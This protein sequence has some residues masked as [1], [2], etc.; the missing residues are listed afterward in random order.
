MSLREKFFKASH[1]TNALQRYIC[2]RFLFDVF[3][4]VGL[5]VTG[6]HFYEVIPN[7]RLVSE[8]YS[9]GPRTLA[10]IDWRFSDGESRALA[11]ID[12]FG[13]EF[14]ESAGRFGFKEDNYYFRGV[15][16]LM[17]YLVLRDVKP[18]TMV[19]V[20]QGFSTRVALAAL[21]RNVSDTGARVRLISIDPYPRFRPD[22]VPR[23]VSLELIQRRIQDVD[24][25]P[26]L[27]DCRLFF[28]DSSHVF[29]FGSDVSFEL[30]TVYPQLQRDAILH[31]H[32]IFSPF[33]YP[34]DWMVKEK[35]FWN[36]QYF[37]ECFLMFNAAFQVYLPLH[38]L[39]RQSVN[40][41]RAVRGCPLVENFRFIGSSLY[42][43]RL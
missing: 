27:K 17:L 36:E 29:K 20:G 9:D 1:E 39:V 30:T 38:L 21:E 7:T 43:K 6:D 42:L 19:E 12:R 11:L 41:T 37:L 5:H 4:R 35:R 34:R 3:Q 24:M 16:A 22:D 25:S 32:D 31:L 14:S 15:D 2:R 18:E 33:D 26:L 8:Q 13:G 40:L 10:G 28:V 23:S